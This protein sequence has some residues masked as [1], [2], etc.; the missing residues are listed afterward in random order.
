MRW[1]G[2]LLRGNDTTKAAG[3]PAISRYIRTTDTRFTIKTFPTPVSRQE[4]EARPKPRDPHIGERLI[5][6]R[7]HPLWVTI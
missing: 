2:P 5:A 3:H 4:G 1:L 7:E 6:E